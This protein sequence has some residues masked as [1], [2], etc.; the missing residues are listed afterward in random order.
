[1]ATQEAQ[2]PLQTPEEIADH[3]AWQIFFTRKTYKIM[4]TRKQLADWMR[5]A[6]LNDRRQRDEEAN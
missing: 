1:M 5:I 2:A 3:L 4:L 6:I